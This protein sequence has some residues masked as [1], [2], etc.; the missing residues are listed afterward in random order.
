[1]SK[2]APEMVSASLGKYEARVEAACRDLQSQRIVERIWDQDHTVWDPDPA[3]IANRL[4]WLR[5]RQVMSDH[6]GE[7]RRMVAELVEQG[8]RDALLLGMGGSSLAAAVF[9]QTFPT[10]SGA[11]AV[12]V[13][14]S[15][16]P[17]AISSTLE[18]LDLQKTIFIVA[19]KS[20]GTIETLSLFKF[21]FQHLIDTV[22]AETAGARFIAITDPGSGLARIAERLG[23]R[24]VLLNDPTI[25]GRYSA[26]S[27]FGL[28]PAAFQGIDIQQLLARAAAVES[29][30][31]AVP[32][33]DSNPAAWL[34]AA[35]AELAL[36]GRDKLTLVLPARIAGLGDWVEQLVAEST[37]KQGMG[38]LPVV[39]E[40]LGE[41][42]DY[43]PDRVFV[44][45]QLG[46]VCPHA[47]Q[48]AAL[49]AAGHPVI[50]L[51]LQDAHD[52]AGQ[53]FLW[54]FAVAVAGSLLGIQPFNQPNVES[55]KIRA[56]EMLAAFQASG[57][58]PQTAAPPLTPSALEDFL[59]QAH[60]GDYIALMAFVCPSETVDRLLLQLR[61]KLRRQTRLA[62]TTGYGPRFLH[63]TGQLHKGDRG[64]G[65]FIQ[66]LTADQRDLPIP[67]EPGAARSAVSFGVLKQAQALGDYQALKD[68]GRRVMR[69]SLGADPA[70]GLEHYL[71]MPEKSP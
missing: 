14:D 29:S 69:F 64:N 33:I 63:S 43:P 19:T 37:G 45:F 41:A 58:L 21:F 48:L 34:G 9:Q 35:L 52:L 57:D 16:D 27:Y 71:A 70:A 40:V 50:H 61:T 18:R 17:M 38:I 24:A 2:P 53:F 28:I 51:G 68:A 3:E 15:I 26:L 7:I 36:A 22:D 59:D 60:A 23:F 44:H 13:L 11:M 56:R 12:H 31:R 39:G 1:M 4:G 30:T 46:E 8:F 42:A 20:G 47:V 25:G 5:S 10:A 65:L 6:L 32:G 62:V 49:Q 55:A 66:L 54:E 67:D